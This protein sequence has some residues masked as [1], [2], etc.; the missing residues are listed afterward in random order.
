M[1]TQVTT[2]DFPTRF[3]N[4][5][6]T[7]YQTNYHTQP[8]MQF[9]MV[10]ATKQI[11]T[12]PL[13]RVQSSCIFGEVFHNKACDCGEQLE[14]SLELISA[15]G[16]LLFYL[17]QEGRGHGIIDKVK[18]LS[19]QQTKGLDTVEASEELGLKP[20]EREFTV[21]ADILKQM[22]IP[23]IKLLTNNPKKVR[24]LEMAGIKIDQRVPLE[25][26]VTEHNKKY[27]RAKKDKLGHLFEGF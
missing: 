9:A 8:R 2:I 25:I 26:E 14:R 12:I 24:E 23:T 11:P 15:E 6:L 1:L 21:V 3:G 10:F 17:D 20:D 7:T 16:G 13:V 5:N 27:L 22:H 19:L 18:E 4:F